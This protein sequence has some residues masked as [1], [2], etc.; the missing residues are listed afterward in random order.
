MYNVC[1]RDN[2]IEEGKNWND[3]EN[4][5]S[6]MMRDNVE[7][8]EV[9]QVGIEDKKSIRALFTTLNTSNHT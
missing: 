4:M 9:G 3:R 2:M 6:I 5:R 7:S 1:K 8:K